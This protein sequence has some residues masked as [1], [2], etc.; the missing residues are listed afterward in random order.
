[1]KS[2]SLSEFFKH[3]GMAM[4]TGGQT[5]YDMLKLRWKILLFI[6]RHPRLMF[7]TVVGMN[8]LHFAYWSRDSTKTC[9]IPDG[10]SSQH[11]SDLH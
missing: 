2:K 3:S 4:K 1:M 8:L 10:P 5:A 6:G 9:Q 11:S 7:G